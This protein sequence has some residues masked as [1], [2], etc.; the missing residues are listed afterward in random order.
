MLRCGGAAVA[1]QGEALKEQAIVFGSEQSGENAAIRQ[2]CPVGV[3]LIP[4]GQGCHP[5]HSLEKDF[6]RGSGRQPGS[7]RRSRMPLEGL[8][9]L[10]RGLEA[11]MLPSTQSTLSGVTLGDK[12][13]AF[14]ATGND[15]T[16]RET[17]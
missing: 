6:L 16:V 10:R 12:E 14:R 7:V 1:K 3:A 15:L 9:R 2:S 4:T 17:Q 5:C 13:T 11:A 8:V